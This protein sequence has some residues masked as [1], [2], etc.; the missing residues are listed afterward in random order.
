MAALMAL[1]TLSCKKDN[2][3]YSGNF[4]EKD[5]IGRWACTKVVHSDGTAD[6][7]PQ[8]AYLFNADHTGEV[9]Y[10]GTPYAVSW[11]LEKGAKLTMR[12]GDGTTWSPMIIGALDGL[13]L[14]Y[15]QEGSSFYYTNMEKL[16][17]GSWS[18]KIGSVTYTVTID[19]SGTS[20][21]KQS[22]GAELGAHTWSLGFD[23]SR[24]VFKVTGPKINDDFKIW[25][26]SDDQLDAL[27]NTST[28][29]KFTRLS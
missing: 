13:H 26:V 5:L 27:D 15:T 2:E 24:V 17:P 4:D 20:T 22:G 9:R 10:W 28:N 25:T 19:K 6:L 14:F 16:L 21:W 12:Q 18:V 23:E 7:N 11:K 3:H 1:G 8:F 29:V